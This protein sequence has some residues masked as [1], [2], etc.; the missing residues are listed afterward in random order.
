MSNLYLQETKQNSTE[1]SHDQ[2]VDGKTSLPVSPV[3]RMRNLEDQENQEN[4][5]N[6]ETTYRKSPT[7]VLKGGET[8]AS[9]IFE[10]IP[11]QVGNVEATNEF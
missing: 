10:E 7:K 6:I 4:Q 5:E 11:D 2:S 3:K 9:P 1:K 8:D